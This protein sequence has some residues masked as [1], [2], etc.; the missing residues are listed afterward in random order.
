[1]KRDEDEVVSVE[2]RRMDGWEV[3]RKELRAAE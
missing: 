1:M 3:N 2:A